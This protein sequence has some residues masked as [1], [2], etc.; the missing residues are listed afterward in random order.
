MW[1]AERFLIGPRDLQDVWIPISGPLALLN[2]AVGVVL[3]TCLLGAAV[4]R[5]LRL[6]PPPPPAEPSEP[7]ESAGVGAAGAPHRA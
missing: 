1:E 2:D 3:L 4:D 7:E 5:V 6:Q